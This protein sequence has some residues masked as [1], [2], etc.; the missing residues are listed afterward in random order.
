MESAIPD[1]RTAKGHDGTRLGCCAWPGDT[2]LARQIRIKRLLLCQSVRDMERLVSWDQSFKSDTESD[3]CLNL[4]VPRCFAEQSTQ[5]CCLR[6]RVVRDATMEQSECSRRREAE[7]ETEVFHSVRAPKQNAALPRFAART[8][9]FSCF[10]LE[11]QDSAAHHERLA[12]QI[13]S[14]VKCADGLQV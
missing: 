6:R 1:Q 12:V 9:F 13:R 3:R 5:A 11:G 7:T 10:E 8:L 2:G 14:V 4:A